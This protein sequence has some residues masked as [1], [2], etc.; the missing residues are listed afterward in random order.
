[1]QWTR[2][3]TV[4][5][6]ASSCVFCQGLGLKP[7][8]GQRR[9]VPC[10]CVFRE[11]FRLCFQKFE[12]C[13]KREKYLSHVSGEIYGSNG[14]RRIVWSRKVEEYIAD[15]CLVARRTLD[16]EEWRVFNAR[17]LMGGEWELCC[18]QLRMEKGRYFHTVYRIQNKL[19]RAFREVTP[20][21]LF[22]LDEY[23]RTTV[24]SA[25]TA[26][27]VWEAHWRSAVL[28]A[29]KR[30]KVVPIR[31][32]LRPK[33]A[34]PQQ[35]PSPGPVPVPLVS[36]RS[37]DVAPLAGR[38]LPAPPEGRGTLQS[39][40]EGPQLWGPGAARACLAVPPAAAPGSLPS[41]RPASSGPLT[42]P[43]PRAA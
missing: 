43:L 13:V 11:I 30:R 17:F 21:A 10:K 33:T 27:S 35:V 14:Q 4:A 32:P 34:A 38:I 31:P 8:K 12:R 2:S 5:L 20:Y 29:E 15:F 16:E 42:L 1:M 36:A 28:E 40:L 25:R 24:R 6:A 22:P 19:G 23:F 3:E 9:L 41:D 18:R 26:S 7:G 37:G 39:G